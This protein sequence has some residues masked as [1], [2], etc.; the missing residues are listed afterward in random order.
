MDPHVAF[1]LVCRYLTV[2]EII[3]LSMLSKQTQLEAEEF[4][5]YFFTVRKDIINEYWLDLFLQNAEINRYHIYDIL[6][7]FQNCVMNKTKVAKYNFKTLSLFYALN[8]IDYPTEELKNLCQVIVHDSIGLL[9]SKSAML[10]ELQKILNQYGRKKGDYYSCKNILNN[11]IERFETRCKSMELITKDIS[12]HLSNIKR[13]L[14]GK[15]TDV[16]WQDRCKR[17]KRSNTE[18]SNRYSEIKKIHT[19][20]TH[21]AAHVD[22]K[23]SYVDDINCK[24][25]E[26]K[27]F[28]KYHQRIELIYLNTIK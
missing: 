17:M 2:Y 21:T 27:Q 12:S 10:L 19:D 28:M 23:K 8:F 9:K 25:T 13:A 1:K 15:D 20:I 5:K 24:L 4:Y 22:K 6:D 11:K 16:L 3:N 26:L 7:N 18:L 14:S